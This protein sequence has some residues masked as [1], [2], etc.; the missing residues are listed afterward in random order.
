MKAAL[1][2]Y[3]K[4]EL[5]D[6]MTHIVRTYVVEGTLPLQGD[7]K[8]ADE[9]LGKLAGLSFPEVVMHLQMRLDHREWSHFSVSGNDVWVDN[10]SQRVSVTGRRAPQPAGRAASGP[11]PS[12]PAPPPDYAPPEP[13][14]PRF[15]GPPQRPSQPSPSQPNPAPPAPAQPGPPAAPRPEA[16]PFG[17]DAGT[18]PP[19]STLPPGPEL[20]TFPPPADPPESP[21]PF[22]DTDAEASER[23][24]MLELD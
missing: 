7:E 20:D 21:D 14:R 15:S 5:I 18:S 12:Q 8:P 11:A 24:G 1:E 22:D 16:S 4:E 17:A 6:L 2:N 10:G 13:G 9:A 19:A 3:S 23:F